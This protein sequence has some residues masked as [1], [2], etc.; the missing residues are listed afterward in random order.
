VDG[1][2]FMTALVSGGKL[3]GR[4]V[5][6]KAGYPGMTSSEFVT[7][8]TQEIESVAAL[9][10]LTGFVFECR[11]LKRSAKTKIFT[12][13]DDGYPVSSDH[14]RTLLANPIDVAL[15]IFQNELG[16]G[17]PPALPESA[18]KLY[19][20]AQWNAANTSNPTLIRPN[21][22]LDV[23]QFLSYR[24]G[25]FAGYLFD[26]A[27]SQPVEAKQFLEY[28]IFRALGGY[29]LVLADGRLSPR[30]FLP[31]FGWITTATSF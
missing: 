21:P 1:A 18:W 23:E 3:E 26:F 31:V 8:A 16:L 25:I 6:L 28:E 7:L 14:P 30:F 22:G 2:G 10:D 12:R 9:P 4:K 20:P 27:L 13:G 11:D 17:Q 19:D 24:N 29:L 5:T 15:L